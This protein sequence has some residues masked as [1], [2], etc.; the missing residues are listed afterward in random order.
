[1]T[2]QMKRS[3]GCISTFAAKPTRHLP[4]IEGPQYLMAHANIASAHPPFGTVLGPWMIVAQYADGKWGTTDVRPVAPL[5]LH[6]AAHVLH[7]ASTCFEG[8]KAYQWA[9]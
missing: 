2:S 9:N 7:Y 1:M 4:S 8:L 5:H 3:M 6:P